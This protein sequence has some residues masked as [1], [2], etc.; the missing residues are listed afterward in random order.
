MPPTSG[1][2]PDAVL[3]APAQTD[4]PGSALQPQPCPEC[5]A[6]FVPAQ[7]GQLF[8]EAAHRVAWHNRWT[9]RGRA[10]AELG[11]VA[12]LTRSGTRGRWRFAQRVSRD[13]D[14]LLARWSR[15]DAAAGRMDVRDYMDRRYAAGHGSL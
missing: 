7:P 10:W 1:A 5:L 15:E 2:G 8:C 14:V 3:H 13:A 6:L 9:V 4:A 12:R 11:A